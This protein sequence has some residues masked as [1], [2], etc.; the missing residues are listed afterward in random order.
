MPTVLVPSVEGRSGKAGAAEVVVSAED[1]AAAEGDE[2]EA[3]VEAERSAPAPA[4]ARSQG[5]GGDGM[6]K[7]DKSSQD[8]GDLIGGDV[9]DGTRCVVRGWRGAK[10]CQLSCRIR[11]C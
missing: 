3:M 8:R 2:V 6:N 1:E 10:H 4:P 11:M 7:R 9:D 5:F